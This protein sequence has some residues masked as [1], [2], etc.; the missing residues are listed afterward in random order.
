MYY[1]AAR[2]RLWCAVVLGC[3]LVVWGALETAAV[4]ILRVRVLPPVLG[5]KGGGT[6]H[7]I[8]LPFSLRAECCRRYWCV[9]ILA[10]I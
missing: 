10:F 2:T 9:H 3:T 1:S 6:S 4:F 7:I 5:R 8:M